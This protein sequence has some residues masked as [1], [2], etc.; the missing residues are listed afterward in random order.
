MHT[1]RISYSMRRAVRELAHGRPTA[2]P[3]QTMAALRNRGLAEA[4][5]LTP[6]GRE[7][8]ARLPPLAMGRN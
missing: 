1:S 6:A 5:A 3:V 4:G 8:H 7:L 2:V